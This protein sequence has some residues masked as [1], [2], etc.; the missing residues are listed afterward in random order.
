MAIVHREVYRC[1]ECGWDWIP[2][3]KGEVPEN[4]PNR[5]CRSRRWNDGRTREGRI[6]R[7]SGEASGAHT[8]EASVGESGIVVAG[9]QDAVLERDDRDGK[10]TVQSRVEQYDERVGT[11]E[12][13]DCGEKMVHNHR[14][15]R[16]ECE[17]GYVRK[18]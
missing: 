1:D 17:C 6:A 2:R 16:W 10:E 18:K 7:L 4:C 5:E 14:L 12:C 3:K 15:K 13:G 9:G 8:A 11:P